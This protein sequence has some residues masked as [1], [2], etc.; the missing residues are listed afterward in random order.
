MKIDLTDIT[1]LI[2][3]SGSMMSICSDAEGAANA[4]V[5]SQ[6]AVPGEAWVTVLL[7]DA[8][9]HEDWYQVQQ[10]G[11][12][13]EATEVL[14][15]PRGSTALLDAMGQAIV[16]TGER[17]SKIAEADRPGHVVFIVQTDGEENSSRKWTRAQVAQLVR[18]Q[19]DEYDWHFV[20]LGANMD[21][22][23]E[24][25]SLGV[26]AG[27]AQTYDHTGKGVRGASLQVSRAVAERRSGKKGWTDPFFGHLSSDDGKVQQ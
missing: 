14:I 25:A 5:E 17:L 26:R 7:F 6:K 22:I 16:Q 24:G 1:L 21:A 4:F 11:P 9:P 15:K 8:P 27:N 20:F 23:G 10:S 19:A 3:R 18:Q 13:R 12:I 2:D